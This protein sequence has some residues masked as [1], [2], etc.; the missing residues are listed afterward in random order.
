MSED[1]EIKTMEER[2]ALLHNGLA[3]ELGFPM[4]DDVADDIRASWIKCIQECDEAGM[5]I[6]DED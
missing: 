4:W 5:S 1:D 6:I 3:K 2:A